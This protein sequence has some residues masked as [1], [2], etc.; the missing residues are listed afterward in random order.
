MI[1]WWRSFL[2]SL[3]KALGAVVAVGGELLMSQ[4]TSTNLPSVRDGTDNYT[5]RRQS[6]CYQQL[7][8]FVFPCFRGD[9]RGGVSYSLLAIFVKC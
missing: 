9:D 1:T 7:K 4:L 3:V 8:A 5:L 6:F 2:S